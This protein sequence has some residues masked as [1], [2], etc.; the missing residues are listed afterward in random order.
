MSSIPHVS[1]AAF[2]FRRS[3]NPSALERM[4]DE[5]AELSAH[6]QAAEYRL[7]CLIREFDQGGGFVYQGYRSC[8]D[9]LSWRVGLDLGAARE[10]VRVARALVNLPRI[11]EALSRGAISY[12]K[13]RAVTRVATSENEDA[14]LQIALSET[15]SR[16][17][18]IVRA[19]RKA[20]RSMEGR[21]ARVQQKKRSFSMRQDKDGTWAVRGRLT[22]EVGAVLMKAL[23]AAGDVL[24]KEERASGV[25]AE[26]SSPSKTRRQSRADAL[27]LLAESALASGLNPGKSS[28]RYQVVVHADQPVLQDASACGQSV[29]EPGA[30]VSAETSRR[31]ACDASVVVM[32]HD[33]SGNVLEVSPRRSIIPPAIRQALDARD[34]TCRFPGCKARSRQGHHVE[35]WA[36][37]GETKLWNLLNLCH[38]HHEC[39]HD[40]GYRVEVSADGLATFYWPSGRAIPEAPSPPKLS[41][42]PVEALHARSVENGASIIGVKGARNGGYAPIDG[43]YAVDAPRNRA[44]R[45]GMDAGGGFD[46]RAQT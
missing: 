17:E 6:L 25:S 28:E 38:R 12:S 19:W 21:T 22:P 29:L 13:V 30:G 27:R 18:E 45:P 43:D 8:A 2:D 14:L 33:D 35:H 34:E 3:P 44:S 16:V 4:G 20:D 42:N 46:R 36:N 31:I 7:L 24:S 10:R 15:A 1:E 41:K 5:I 23:Q 39:V 40:G 26:T 11:G 9:W 32:T 37:G